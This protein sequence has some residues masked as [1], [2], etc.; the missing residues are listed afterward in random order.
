MTGRRPAERELEVLLSGW[1][2]HRDF[3]EQDQAAA[4]ALTHTGE[5]VPSHQ[6]DAGELAA[7]T[8]VANTIFNLDE[9][10]MKE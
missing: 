1:R 9:T 8:A 6:W 10:V 5:S 7:Y 2:H 3:Y 4:A